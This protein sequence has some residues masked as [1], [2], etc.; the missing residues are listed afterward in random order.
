MNDREIAEACLRTVEHHVAHILTKLG[1]Q[2][3]SAALAAREAGLFPPESL[4]PS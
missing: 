3:R 2:S 4:L 1:V